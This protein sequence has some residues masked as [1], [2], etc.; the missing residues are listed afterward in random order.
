MVVAVATPINSYTGTGGANTYPFT[1]SV[2]NSSQ[3]AV[4]IKSPSSA[5]PANFAYGLVLGIDYLVTGLNAAGTPASPGS[6][7]LV[8]AGQAWLTGANLSTNWTLQIISNFAL[9]QGSSIRN[10]GDFDRGFMEDALDNLEYQIQQLQQA[11]LATANLAGAATLSNG[12]L[13]F[14]DTAN[15]HTY[16]VQIT[17]G[18]WNFIQI[19]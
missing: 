4:T 6:I 3:I 15:G 9:S 10:Q 5:N 11:I 12:I 2:F 16:Q 14:A 1:F 17:N 7:V 19:S 8:N 18:A 13:T